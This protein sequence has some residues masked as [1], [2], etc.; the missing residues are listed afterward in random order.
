[1]LAIWDGARIYFRDMDACRVFAV[2]DDQPILNSMR[3][4]DWG[5]YN[6]TYV[7]DAVNGMDALH[8]LEALLPQIVFVD[9]V[10]PV[11]DGLDF[12]KIAKAK[13]PDAVFVIVSSY[14]DFEYAREAMR[15]GA[16]DYLQKGEFS[17]ADLGKLLISI[18]GR[19]TK[20][21]QVM[22]SHSPYRYEVQ[23]TLEAITGHMQ[24]DLSLESIASGLG[25][26][27][28]YLGTVFFQQTGK[29]FKDYLMEV[30]MDRAK[31]LLLHTPLRIYEVAEQ[32]GYHDVKYFTTSFVKCYQMTPMQLR[33]KK[34]S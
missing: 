8:K 12:L 20:N 19:L 5:R 29:H 24:E 4:F 26:S 21:P 11:M 17:D 6:C 25:L 22:D 3:D 27:T 2:D 14:G 30:R 18:V 23:H 15:N 34:E 1:M 31:Q 13:L 7:G 10:M 9:I 33:L 16:T 28:N 32:V